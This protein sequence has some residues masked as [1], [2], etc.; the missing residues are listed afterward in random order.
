MKGCDYYGMNI[1]LYLDKELIGQDLEEFHAHLEECPTCRTELE[2]EEALSGLLHR[3]RPLYSAPDALRRR[4]LQAADSLPSTA[5]GAPVRL[6][7]RIAK[8]LERPFQSVIR[9]SW[10][11]FV[12]AIL[13][14][15]VGL[16]L[17]PGI[18]RQSRA[19]GY[20]ETA[21]AAHRG[22]LGGSLP[23]EIQSES[24]SIVTAWFAGK[25]PFTFRLPNSAE[26]LG[27]EQTYR[28]VGGR[29][30]NYKSGYAALVA[31]Q[32]QQQRISLLVSSSR[33]AAAAGGEEVPSGGI[34]F[35][36]SKQASFNVITWSTHG[37]T[38]ALVSSLPGS[39]RE[40]CL[41]C[42]QNMANGSHFSAHQ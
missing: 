33:S 3:S 22:F 17:G 24:P 14:V 26:E 11:V 35:H 21:I 39:G 1:Q 9:P 7:K 12:T 19:N 2:E 13:L 25:V 36:Y 34:V 6:E 42:H 41:V 15:A 27:H 31:Y 38:Y 23:L 29:L 20:I 40:S 32:A 28:L 30:V 4:I 5:T 16:L 10:P 8:M 18:L 37:L